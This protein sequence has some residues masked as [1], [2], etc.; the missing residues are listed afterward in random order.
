MKAAEKGSPAEFIQCDGN[1]PN[2]PRLPVKRYVAG[3]M[4]PEVAV[5][6]PVSDDGQVMVYHVNL[7][8]P[9]TSDTRQTLYPSIDAFLNDGWVID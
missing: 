7:F 8:S 5:I 3:Q 1:W 2:W 9:I 4:R 6:G